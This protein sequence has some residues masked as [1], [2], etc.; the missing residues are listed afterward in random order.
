MLKNTESTES[1]R[2]PVWVPCRRCGLE[3]LTSRVICKIDDDGTAT[4][5][6][7]IDLCSDCRSEVKRQAAERQI[8]NE[9]RIEEHERALAALR[10]QVPQQAQLNLT[11]D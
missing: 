1:Q 4:P 11:L 3:V 6:V 5:I 7:A 9:R 10:S 2:E 8:E